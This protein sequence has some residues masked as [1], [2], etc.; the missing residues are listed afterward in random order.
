M[1]LSDTGKDARE[2]WEEEVF[3][4]HR[5]GWH[6]DDNAA[7]E[8][9]RLKELWDAAQ[10]VDA[11]CREIVQKIAALEVCNWNLEESIMAIC[12]GIGSKG[13]IE[14]PIGHLAS[15]SDER[16]KKMWAYY[17][18]LRD[19]LSSKGRSGY[20]TLLRS[21]DP[22]EETKRHVLRML[23]ERNELK[24]L[25]VERFCLCLE[26]WLGGFFPS[27]PA[28]MTG[29]AAA[30]SAVEGEISKRDPEGGLLSAMSI[31][32]GEWL[33]P[34]SH[35][36]FGRY[37]DIVASIGAGEWRGWTYWTVADGLRRVDNIDAYL[38]AIDAWISGKEKAQEAGA[39]GPAKDIHAALGELDAAKS[40]LAS[41]LVSLLRA[42]SLT[43]RSRLKRRAEREAKESQT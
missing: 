38:S 37:D 16:W 13:S 9:S 2:T 11:S 20:G 3:V 5:W 8:H 31:H 30:V 22:N 29:H 42:Q 21:C 40:F 28:Q 41:L 18:T 14:L 10:P 1:G 15:V 39:G 33:G 32:G 24:E 17:L 25:Y 26:Y 12:R 7:E 19:R 4:Q 43:A 23:G 36:A 34:C 35:K 27:D 6:G